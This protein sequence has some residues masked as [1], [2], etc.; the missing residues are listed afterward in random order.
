LGGLHCIASG[1][2][3]GECVYCI[4]DG[5][6]S[7]SEECSTTNKC[8]LKPPIGDMTYQVDVQANVDLYS[9]TADG[10]WCEGGVKEVPSAT[11]GFIPYKD[12]TDSDDV[13]IPWGKSTFLGKSL[14]GLFSAPDGVCLQTRTYT[15]GPAAAV[16]ALRR[17]GFIAEEGEIAVLAGTNSITGT[18]PRSLDSAL[19]GR[20]GREGLE[21]R[22][23][24]FGSVAELKGRGVTLAIVKDAFLIDH[25]VAVLDVSEGMVLVGDPVL[26]KQLIPH[27]QFEQMWRFTGIVLDHE[28]RRRI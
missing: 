4:D 20:Y 24:Y 17:L 12:C 19:R 14:G 10:W 26:G 3:V 1:S 2:K 16:T 25:C 5:D 23:R 21:C 28:S 22:Y 13:S 7:S 27:E 6:C 18:L 15:C 11:N 9:A 8:V